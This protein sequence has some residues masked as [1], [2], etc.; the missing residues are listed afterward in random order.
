MVAL[1][2]INSFP[3]F[4]PHKITGDLEV[5]FP[6]NMTS[7]FVFSS[8]V[9]EGNWPAELMKPRDLHYRHKVFLVAPKSVIVHSPY[10]LLLQFFFCLF[11]P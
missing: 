10:G 7:Y 8:D 4:L 5:L 1:L 2:T 3:F 6:L 11:S 9:K